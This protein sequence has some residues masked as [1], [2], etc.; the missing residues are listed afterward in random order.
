MRLQK[1][2]QANPE[3]CETGLAAHHC[4]N[5]KE[6]FDSSLQLLSKLPHNSLMLR[7]AFSSLPRPGL[8]TAVIGAQFGDE[9]A[10]KHV[11]S[12]AKDFD[13]VARFNGGSNGGHVSVHSKKKLAYNMVPC[14]L[15]HPKTL[16]VI[17]NGVLLDFISLFKELEQLRAAKID[18]SGRLLISDRAHI[19]I[20]PYL[21]HA[22]PEAGQKP[23]HF[24]GRA[25]F[26]ITPALAAK[27]ARQGLRVGDL[28]HWES[29]T[30]KYNAL[31]DDLERGRDLKTDRGAELDYL[32][33]IA[34][35]VKKMTCD[36]AVLL[37][38]KLA[39][40]KSVLAEGTYSAMLDT[41]FGSYPNVVGCTTGT[42]GVSAGLGVPPQKV[43][44]IG[45]VK[46]YTSH[47]LP[48]PFPT[49][50]YGETEQ[51]LLV[52]G[53]EYSLTTNRRRQVGWLDMN[54]LRYSHLLNNYASI[55]L[56]KIEVLDHLDEIKIA[57][58]YRRGLDHI[59]DYPATLEELACCIPV[60]ET[61]PG[62]RTETAGISEWHNLPPEAQAYCLRISELLGTPVSA[63]RTGRRHKD[64]IWASP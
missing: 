36:T 57:V 39:E 60:Y 50:V 37:N 3:H 38:T 46:T 30:R 22:H 64:I 55:C 40:G 49:Q 63:V 45:V 10:C 5:F 59:Q 31:V 13:I 16:N 53:L 56:T 61:L 6:C 7:K 34:P 28:F 25:L 43:N 42:A 51:Q 33:K 17:G 62:W 32:K 48:V 12:L 8:V 29:F 19:I 27:T 23:L 11:E 44:T 21:V 2:L 47:T 20:E 1:V 54:V 35:A 26:G 9:T 24:N 15:V 18:T 52:R 58:S 4:C 14:G 41:D